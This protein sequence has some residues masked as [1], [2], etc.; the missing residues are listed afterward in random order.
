MYK[1]VLYK[2]AQKKIK[3]LPKNLKT[4]I[5]DSIQI[6]ALSPSVGKKL[7]GKLSGSRRLRIGD[8]RIIYDIYEAEKVIVVHTVGSRG[9]VYK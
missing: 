9:D 7:H 5:L 2:S 6:L 3:K 1:V 8:F 4:K